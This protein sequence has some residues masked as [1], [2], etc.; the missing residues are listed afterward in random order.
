MTTAEIVE[1]SVTNNSLSK[2]HLHPDDHPKEI[3]DTPGFK[4]SIALGDT[5]VDDY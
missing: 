3:T 5:L 2:D 1:T 4:P